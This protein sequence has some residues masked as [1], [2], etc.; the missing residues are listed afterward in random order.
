[1]DF[2]TVYLGKW[3]CLTIEIELVNLDALEKN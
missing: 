3:W 2:E 1:M